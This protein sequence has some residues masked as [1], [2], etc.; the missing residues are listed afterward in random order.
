MRDLGIKYH[1][2]SEENEIFAMIRNVLII[3][4]R[5]FFIGELHG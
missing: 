3:N 4:T 5:S 1:I 2:S